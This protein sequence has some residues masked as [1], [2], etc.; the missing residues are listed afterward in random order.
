MN[1]PRTDAQ[2]VSL[3]YVWAATFAASMTRFQHDHAA[4]GRGWAVE[5]AELDRMA[6]DAVTI[7]DLTVA[8]LARLRAREGGR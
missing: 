8:A 7:A 6:E 3:D 2:A 4:E 1:H 5:D